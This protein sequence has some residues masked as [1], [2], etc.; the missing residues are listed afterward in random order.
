MYKRKDSD[1]FGTANVGYAPRIHN[2]T[3]VDPHAAFRKRTELNYE[4]YQ[5]ALTSTPQTITARPLDACKVNEEADFEEDYHRLRK[6]QDM[7]SSIFYPPSKRPPSARQDENDPQLANKP[8]EGNYGRKEVFKREIS[9]LPLNNA[10]LR[11]NSSRLFDLDERVKAR[12]EET[13]PLAPL[14]PHQMSWDQ[15]D[16]IKYSH[17]NPQKETRK[18]TSVV[19]CV[20]ESKST[21]FEEKIETKPA[22]SIE[23]KV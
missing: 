21:V 10:Q 13:V 3:T 16:S 15:H 1:I 2:P 12:G 19:N 5:A 17:I 8:Q 6:E 7:Q 14:I 4:R 11:G 22:K 18:E 23:K 9:G 20:E